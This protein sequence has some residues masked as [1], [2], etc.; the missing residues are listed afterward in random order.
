MGAVIILGQEL[1]QEK[2][3][4][5]VILPGFVLEPLFERADK[6]LGDAIGTQRVPGPMT[7]DKDMNETCLKAAERGIYSFEQIKNY[8]KN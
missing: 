6:A 4:L 8:T 1:C 2:G 5:L 7:G 3:Q